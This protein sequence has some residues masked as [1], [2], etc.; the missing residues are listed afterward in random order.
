[1]L[2]AWEARGVIHTRT[3]AAGHSRFGPDQRA[4][5]RAAPQADIQAALAPNGRAAVAWAAQRLTEGGAMGTITYSAAVRGVAHGRFDLERRLETQP[6]VRLAS[7]V[8]LAMDS[9]GRG[10]VAW[11]GA[12]AAG[13]L[14]V[15]VADAPPGR[16]FLAGRDVS[17]PGADSRPAGLVAGPGRRRLVVWMTGT[18]DGLGSVQAAYAP[19]AGD[20]GAPEIVSPGPEA[21]V[22]R[23]AFDPVSGRATVVWSERP[24]GERDTFAR[25]ATR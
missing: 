11:A 16:P 20:F 19:P 17:A 13:A 3:L 12:T 4:N 6:G 25:A 24:P 1:V 7:P 18:P 2:A 9:H 15:R 10:T 22:P 5:H 14:V 23:A 8:R 21:R